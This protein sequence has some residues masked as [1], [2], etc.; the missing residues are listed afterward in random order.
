MWHEEN[1]SKLVVLYWNLR[2]K[3]NENYNN[4]HSNRVDY[5]QKF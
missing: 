1:V 5:G 2:G 4:S 3:N